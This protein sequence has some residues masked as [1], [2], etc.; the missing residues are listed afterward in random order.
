MARKVFTELTSEESQQDIL[1]M[2]VDKKQ[3]LD[4]LQAEVKELG[5]LV[6]S[7][8]A[9]NDVKTVQVNGYKITKSESVR[10]TWKD[11]L[12]LQKVKSYNIPELVELV[13]QVNM[14]ELEQC[15]LDGVIN[16]QDLS[17]CNTTTT[18]V[19]LRLS[20]VKEVEQ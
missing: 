14:T 11:D 16:P 9:S 5:T 15:V 6:K 17:E 12:L 1:S 13:E 3:Q 10:I 8:M 4:K 7:Q 19:T 18:V 20:K 2:Y